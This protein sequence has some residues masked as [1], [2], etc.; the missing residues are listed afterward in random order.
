M[1]RLP[2]KRLHYRRLTSPHGKTQ[3]RSNGEHGEREECAREQ[4]ARESEQES[5]GE[6]ERER[7]RQQSGALRIEVVPVLQLGSRKLKE[8]PVRVGDQMLVEQRY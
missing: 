5:E 6:S 8:T 4:T 7:E 1:L 3:K 2:S